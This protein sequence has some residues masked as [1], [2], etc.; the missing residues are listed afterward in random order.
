[1]EQLERICEQCGA[2]ITSRHALR[3]CA[4]ACYAAWNQKE[5]HPTYKGRVMHSGGYLRVYAPSNP[6]AD[7]IG[8]VFEH[9]LV[10]SEHLGRPLDEHEEVHHRNHIKTDNRLDNLELLVLGA[11][12]TQHMH[13]RGNVTNQFGTFELHQTEESRK[14]AKKAGM[15]RWREA[16]REH[17]RAYRDGRRAAGL[18]Y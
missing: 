1:V 2:A 16:N 17:I 9:R 11:H 8:Y 18:A 12:Q 6:M 4:R 7:S 13:E 10:M 14:A 5:N 3:F 15:R